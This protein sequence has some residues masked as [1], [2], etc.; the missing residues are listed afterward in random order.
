[1]NGKIWLADNP[2]GGTRFNISF[3]YENDEH[4]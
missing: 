3:I 2:G 4:P 1:M